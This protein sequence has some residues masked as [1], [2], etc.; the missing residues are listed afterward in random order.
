MAIGRPHLIHNAVKFSFT[1]R[2]HDLILR[3]SK[4][5]LKFY[6]LKGDQSY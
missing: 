1:L 2:Q 3:I 4:F 5:C 6:S